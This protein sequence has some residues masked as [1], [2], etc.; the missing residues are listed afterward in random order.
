[1]ERQPADYVIAQIREKLA[2]LGELGISVDV[3]EDSVYLSGVVATEQRRIAISNVLGE[4]L[5]G[6]TVYNEVEVE[7]LHAPTEAE[8][9]Q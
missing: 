9:I 1:M 2:S 6:L 4:L 3:V 5:P 7:E 8:N